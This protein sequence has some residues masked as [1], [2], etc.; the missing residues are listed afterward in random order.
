MN[1]LLIKPLQLAILVLFFSSSCASQSGQKLDSPSWYITPSQN[2]SKNLYGVSTGYTLEESTKYALADAASRLMVNI[3]STSTLLREE[4]QVGI[5]EEMRQQVRQNVE[6][7][8]F[9]NFKVSKSKKYGQKIFT[10]VEIERAP[11]IRDQKEKVN[12]LKRKIANLDKNS[13][14]KNAIYRRNSLLKI[15]DLNKELELKSRI[16]LGA[17]ENI[18]LRKTLNRIA[19]FQDQL[20]RFSDKI[21]FYFQINSP[22]EIAKII[23][24]SLNKEQ[25]KVSSKRNS[26]NENQ[27]VIKVSSTSRNNEIYGSF[28]AKLEIDFENIA[29]GKTVASNSVEVV[30]SSTIGKKE[31][32]LSALKSLEEKIS[33]DSILK[34]IGIL[35]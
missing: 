16:L 18:N 32:Y 12:F 22:K 30:G 34:I 31:A 28:M 7:I 5:N 23:R 17:G 3:S 20:E 33:E 25:L 8:S 14:N 24:T 26:S 27:V 29:N 4:N 35:N 11:F 15:C 10:E 6:K 13:R 2:N 9:A 1:K 19:D 21:E